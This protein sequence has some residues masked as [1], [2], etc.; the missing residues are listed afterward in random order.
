MTHTL[1][2]GV[3]PPSGAARGSR[4]RRTSVVCDAGT[5]TVCPP[6]REVLPLV[7]GTRPGDVA[8]LHRA[9][10]RAAARPGHGPLLLPVAQGEDPS[11]LVDLAREAAARRPGLAGRA[12]V[13]LRTSGSTT[14]AGSL[15][16]MGARALLAS[17]RATHNRLGGPGAWVLALPAHHVAGLQVLLRSVVA[18][19]RPQV[20]DTSAGFEPE[21]LAGL[22][23]QVRAPDRAGGRARL[24]LSLVPTQLRRCLDSPRGASAL[25]RC[26]AV[27]VGGAATGQDLLARARAAGV[28][29]V[30]T[31]GMSETGGGCVYDGVA[32]EGVGVGIEDPGPDGAGRVVLT[33]PVLAEGYL[34]GPAGATTSFRPSSGTAPRAVV[35]A[36]RGRLEGGRLTVLGRLDDV[37][38]TGGVKV[39]PREV[40][41]VLTQVPGV[42]QACVVGLPDEQW[43]SAVIAVVVARQGPQVSAEAL[44]AAAR[45]RL[46]GAHAPKEVVV[47]GS[48]PERGPG[49]T[50]RRAVAQV[51]AQALA[52]RA[53]PAPC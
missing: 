42:A 44:R 2:D 43:G 37:I 16:A 11:A 36:D 29:V 10:A 21:A 40:E 46:D 3:P 17:A 7:G 1:A 52:R 45:A 38:V 6:A 9:L 49:K 19:T 32:L 28:R 14:G 48:L 18:G 5:V 27:L 24:Y 51:A 35:T 31:Y 22:L 15:V 4:S 25:A 13:L 53:E 8:L 50:D 12:D 20:L 33:G 30:T 26:S 39:E 34:L 47:V 41:E 23:E